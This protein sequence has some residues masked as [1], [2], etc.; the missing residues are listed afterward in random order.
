MLKSLALAFLFC[1]LVFGADSAASGASASPEGDART[2]VLYDSTGPWAFL[3]EVYGQQT[4]NLVS[5]FGSWKAEPVARYQAGEM[6]GFTA[7][8]YLGST[9]DEPLPQAFL[10][11]VRDRLRPMLWAGMNLWQ[12]TRAAPAF[13]LGWAGKGLDASLV[14]AVDYKGIRLKRNALNKAGIYRTEVTDSTKAQV[15]AEACR[16]DGTRFPWAIRSGTFVYLGEVPMAFLGERDRYLAFA[17]LLFEV[18][19]P[20]APSRH[21]ALVRIEDVGPNSDPAQLLALGDVLGSRGIP[22]S[23]GVYPSYRDP[24]GAHHKGMDTRIELASAPAVVAALKQLVGRGGTLVMHGITHQSGASANPYTGT[25]GEDFEFY[26]AKVDSGNNV[27][28]EGPVEGDSQAWAEG[29]IRQGAKAF[30]EAGLPAPAF[31]EPPHYAASA[32]DYQAITAVF[33]RRYDRGLYF[34]G[35]W[36]GAPDAGRAV[37]QFFPFPVRDVYGSLVLPENLGA[38]YPVSV[39]NHPLSTVE[40]LLETGARNRVVRDGFASFFYHPHLGPAGLAKV[41]DGL[42]D[43][44]WTFV[45]PAGACP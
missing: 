18:L 38:V 9:Y 16:A 28:L 36:G 13:A 31:F 7:V 23:V 40:D 44:G 35:F 43:Q 4:A 15:L 25:S 17:D 3:G 37:S 22:F 39:N 29:R 19:A 12:V 41:V 30:Q 34:P 6:K 24:L 1:S 11:D 45:A 2:L 26:R 20:K 33:G 8:V 42:R 5:H 27:V 14:T 10:A 32:A 21:R